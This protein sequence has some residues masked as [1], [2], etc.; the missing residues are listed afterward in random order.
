MS[1]EWIQD[2]DAGRLIVRAVA[3]HDDQIIDQ[4]GSGNLLIQ[5]ILRMG[6]A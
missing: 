6:Y 5:G 3:G 4:G 1:G 2:P